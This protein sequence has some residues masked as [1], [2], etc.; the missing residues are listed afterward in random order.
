MTKTTSGAA[1]GLRGRGGRRGWGR[2][3]DGAANDQEDF[4][5]A[6]QYSSLQLFGRGEIGPTRL[7]TELAAPVSAVH[8]SYLSPKEE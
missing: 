6:R 5:T 3:P 4:S 1:R 8:R 2:S 7:P